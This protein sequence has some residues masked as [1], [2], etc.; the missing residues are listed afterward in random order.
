MQVHFSF[1]FFSPACQQT[2]QKQANMQD[3]YFPHVT[4]PFIS[5]EGCQILSQS[6][7]QSINQYTPLVD[8]YPLVSRFV[9]A[10][11]LNRTLNNRVPATKPHPS[12]SGWT[13]AHSPSPHTKPTPSPCSRTN[14][15]RRRKQIGQCVKQGSGLNKCA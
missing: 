10:L 14:E 5:S 8:F 7:D 13:P 15:F 2:T 6:I 9:E 11:F 12:T 3:T 4:Q 1:L